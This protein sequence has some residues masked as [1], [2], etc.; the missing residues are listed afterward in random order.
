VAIIVLILVSVAGLWAV[1]PIER[2]QEETMEELVGG[3]AV[4]EVE[5]VE[6]AIAAEARV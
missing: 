5:S 6:K 3:E 2:A 1:R 4:G